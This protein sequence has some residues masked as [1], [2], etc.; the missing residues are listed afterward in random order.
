MQIHRG[1]TPEASWILASS[2]I[3][4]ILFASPTLSSLAS[5]QR[6]KNNLGTIRP[7]YMPLFG[8]GSDS[9]KAIESSSNWRKRVGVKVDN[10]QLKVEKKEFYTEGTESTEFTEDA[11]RVDAGS[12]I[13]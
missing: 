9:H 1:K 3:F 10:R 6:F 4:W 11:L 2:S 8:F 5:P 7:V 12:P 13:R